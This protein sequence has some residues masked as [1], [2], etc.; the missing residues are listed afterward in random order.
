[1]V[2]LNIHIFSI[3]Y[4]PRRIERNVMVIGGPGVLWQKA[5]GATLQA[6]QWQKGHK[7]QKAITLADHNKTSVLVQKLDTR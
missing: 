4:Q 7:W 2:W 6:P 1:M 3:G 5:I